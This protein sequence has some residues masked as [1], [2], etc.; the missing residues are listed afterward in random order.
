MILI[1]SFQNKPPGSGVPVAGITL[2]SKPSTSKV[3]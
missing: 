2:E 3:K 1:V